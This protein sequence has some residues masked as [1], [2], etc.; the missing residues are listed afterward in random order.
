MPQLMAINFSSRENVGKTVFDFWIWHITHYTTLE[1]NVW[2]T[3]GTD[4]T[5]PAWAL[6]SAVNLLVMCSNMNCLSTWLLYLL[7]WPARLP[8]NF[9]SYMFPKAKSD[10]VLFQILYI[11]SHQ[12]RGYGHVSASVVSSGN[13]GC[14]AAYCLFLCGLVMSFSEMLSDTSISVHNCTQSS[15]P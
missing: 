5:A 3:N 8:P 14:L 12:H 2:E 10:F 7:F 13:P 9:W 15:N 6:H 1:K 4:C 11:I